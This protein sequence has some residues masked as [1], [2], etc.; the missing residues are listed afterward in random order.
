MEAMQVVFPK[1]LLDEGP[2]FLGVLSLSL[3]ALVH[4]EPFL[5]AN[6]DPD[7][8]FFK[9]PFHTYSIAEKLRPLLVQPSDHPDNIDDT[10]LFSHSMEATGILPHTRIMICQE[11]QRQRL[12]ALTEQVTALR[13]DLTAHHANTK[14]VVMEALR[15]VLNERAHDVGVMTPQAVME[16]VERAL[17]VPVVLIFFIYGYLSCLPPPFSIV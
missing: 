17:Q 10:L 11:Q 5:R 6:L 8:G 16:H 2:T 4:H 13:E 1:L 9:C 14:E 15:E 12:E 3:A 7:H